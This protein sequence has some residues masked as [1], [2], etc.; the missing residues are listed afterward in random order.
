MSLS[1]PEIPADA[2]IDFPEGLPGFVTARRF[3]ILQ[4]EEIQPLLLLHTI[5]GAPLGLPVVPI[6]IARPDYHL[7]IP[8]DDRRLLDLPNGGG[9]LLCLAVVV[10]NAQP[11]CN[12][13]APIVIN[14]RKLIGKQILQLDCDYSSA[15]PLPVR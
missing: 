8:P 6:Q 14:P 7:E 5:E 13:M 15:F 3:V 4:S 10:L 11:T 2:V 12:L 9:A 1:L